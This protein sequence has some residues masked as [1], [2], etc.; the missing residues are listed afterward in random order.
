LRILSKAYK[1]DVI[2]SI[3][4]GHLTGACWAI[5]LLEAIRLISAKSDDYTITFICWFLRAQGAHKAEAKRRGGSR[6]S[7]NIRQTT[8]LIGHMVL[9]AAIRSLLTEMDINP[10]P[11][12]FSSK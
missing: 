1:F 12:V 11:G 6:Y 3:W 10:F 9:L 7:R 8:K 4:G 5:T 2:I